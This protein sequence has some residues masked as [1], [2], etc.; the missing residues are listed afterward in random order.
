MQGKIYTMIH[1][2]IDRGCPYDCTYCGAPHLRRLFFE[3]GCG[4]YYRRKD[5]DRV[6]EE[7][8]FLAAK[9]NPDYINFNSESFLAKPLCG[10][11]KI[12]QKIS[13]D[14]AAILVSDQTRDGYV[15]R[16]SRLLKD[17]GCQNMQFG[18]EHGN[19]EFRKRVLNRHYSNEQML[20]ALK[21]V[22]EILYS[23]YSK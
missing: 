9:Y 19:E 7:M 22:E 13:G 5:V 10:T 20:K 8:K 21:I 15:K 2:E 12:C 16:R 3:K 11:K 6:I 1:V 18:I 4:I 14:R 23:L 17:M